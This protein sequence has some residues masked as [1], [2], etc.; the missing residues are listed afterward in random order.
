MARGSC[1]VAC[2][3]DETID[4]N[5]YGGQ[6]EPVIVNSD[7]TAPR[8][9]GGAGEMPWASWSPDGKELVTLSRKGV[10]FVDLETGSVRKT[11]KRQGFFQQL[12]WSPDGK[13]LVGVANN[14]A[15]GWSIARMD[16]DT[17]AVSAVNTVDCCTPDWFPDTRSVIFSW[18]PPGQ[19]TNH[20]LRL[21]PALACRRRRARPPARLRRGRPS[22][23]R[24][25]RLA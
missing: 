18:R 9:L 19:K 6:G 8:V 20:G 13:W 5:R 10:S 23:L 4:G 16:V 21:D 25:L 3:A 1:I 2:G 17:G 15:T 14:F 12:T 24:R 7:G 22:R 11:L